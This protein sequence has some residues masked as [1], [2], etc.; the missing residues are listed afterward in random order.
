MIGNGYLFARKL[1]RIDIIPYE[2]ISR[3]SYD[4]VGRVLKKWGIR[5]NLRESLPGADVPPLAVGDAG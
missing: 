5:L 1:Q 3:S 2:W 4:C